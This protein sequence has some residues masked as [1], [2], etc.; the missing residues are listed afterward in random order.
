MIIQFN[1]N[2]SVLCLIRRRPQKEITHIPFPVTA[3]QRNLTIAV[4]GYIEPRRSRSRLPA[5]LFG[6]GGKVVE[7]DGPRKLYERV[8][9]GDEFL[10]GEY[11]HG[12]SFLMNSAMSCPSLGSS[13]VDI[14]MPWL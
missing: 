12:V 4:R 14:R 8:G 2:C 13:V 10:W 9:P 1:S 3:D 11:D 7:L 5:Q 6:V